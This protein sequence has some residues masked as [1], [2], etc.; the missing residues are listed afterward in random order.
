MKR[1]LVSIDD[2]SMSD[3]SRLFF[4]LRYKQDAC[5]LP[6]APIVM[7]YFLE[8][9]TRTHISFEMAAAKLG[10]KVISFN[11]STS[12]LNKGESWFESLLTL[13]AM[14]PD[15]IITRTPFL[16][17]EN[18]VE[19]IQAAIINGGDGCNEH[20][21]QAL[22]DCYTLLEHFDCEDLDGKNILIVGDILHS[23]VAHSNIKLFQKF[24]AKLSLLAPPIFSKEMYGCKHY[25]SFSDV[26][27]KKFDAVMVLRIQ[28]ERLEREIGMSDQDYFWHFGMSEERFSKMADHCVLLHPGPMNNKVEIDG[29]LRGH[30]R[31][32]ISKQVENGV[33]VR[34]KL[35]EQFFI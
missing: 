30:I 24:K 10:A 27:H 26:D 34:K 18:T 2:L 19:Q 1:R 7:I 31:S 23:R 21:T 29:N 5:R 22:L 35:L 28:K 16:L 4:E 13:D 32:L 3:I 6:R 8:S 15:V 20:P 14:G 12:S 33:L 9:S 25:S 11:S 17:E